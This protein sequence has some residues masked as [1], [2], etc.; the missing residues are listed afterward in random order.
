MMMVP[1]LTFQDLKLSKPL[2]QAVQEM[3]YSAPTPIQKKAIPLILGGN[4]VLCIA[5]TGTGKT[6]AYLLPLLMKLNY[7]T[8]THPRALVLAPSKELVIQIAA[9]LETVRSIYEDKRLVSS[10]SS[11]TCNIHIILWW[12]SCTH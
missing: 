6:A 9:N 8:G 12:G 10:K 5:Q 11:S 3:G 1:S 4:D 7:A 2:L